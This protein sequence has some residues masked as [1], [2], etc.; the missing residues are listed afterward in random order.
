M[1]GDTV[2]LEDYAKA[3]VFNR[4]FASIGDRDG[5]TSPISLLLL[6]MTNVYVISL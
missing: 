4:Y 2:V 5:V 1:D 3:N 6:M